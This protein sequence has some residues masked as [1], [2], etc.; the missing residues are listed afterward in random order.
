MKCNKCGNEFENEKFCP[1][2]GYPASS[3][4]QQAENMLHSLV[5]ILI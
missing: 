3:N 1:V 2:C 4:G 5:I